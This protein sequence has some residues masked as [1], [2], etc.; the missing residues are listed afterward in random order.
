MFWK[1][2]SFSK[3]PSK[4]DLED[5]VSIEPLFN[6]LVIFNTNDTTFHGHPTSL[7]FPEN[8][9]RTSLAF[10]YYTSKK[11]SFK[12]RKRFKTTTTR[13]IASKNSK[14]QGNGVKLKTKIGYLL[15][16]WTPFF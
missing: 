14:F 9:P 4:Q 16:R 7:K 10:Y 12:E 11:R 8:Y 13:Y 2:T 6:R 3:N 15:R 1:K 5:M